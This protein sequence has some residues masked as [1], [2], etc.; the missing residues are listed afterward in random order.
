MKGLFKQ[1][2][3]KEPKLAQLYKVLYRW[4]T[5][6]SSEEKPVTGHMVIEKAKSFYD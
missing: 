2:T 1:Q 4:F 3:L 6:M 5:A